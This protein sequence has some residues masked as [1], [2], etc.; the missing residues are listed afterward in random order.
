MSKANPFNCWK[1]L[2]ITK[3]QHKNETNLSVMVM[4]IEKISYMAY[5]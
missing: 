5:G 2:K 1:P 3:P 4:K